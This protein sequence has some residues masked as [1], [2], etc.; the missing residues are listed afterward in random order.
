[1]H[2]NEVREG[3]RTVMG[4]VPA[5]EDAATKASISFDEPRPMTNDLGNYRI[6]RTSPL[7][8]VPYVC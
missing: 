8:K 1:L 6:L 7:T 2:K 5:M 4:G 3:M